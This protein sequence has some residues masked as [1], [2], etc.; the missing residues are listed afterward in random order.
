MKALHAY[1]RRHRAEH[2]IAALVASGCRTFSILDVRG[3]AHGAAD[4]ELDY[5]VALAQR[6]E[7]VVK[8]EIV[9]NDADAARW[10]PL[11]VQ[12]AYTGHRGDG[13]VW[14]FPVDAAI[15]IST[16]VEGE[17]ALSDA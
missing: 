15:R 5:S 8:I 13:L 14:I 3:I 9:A 17:P 6:V 1:I 11:V 10:A 7:H 16:G 4:G 12:A 2:V